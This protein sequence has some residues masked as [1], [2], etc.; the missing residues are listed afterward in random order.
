[1]RFLGLVNNDFGMRYRLVTCRG[2]AYAIF[3]VKWLYIGSLTM[4]AAGSALCGAAPNMKALI[5]GRVW[6]GAGGAG[7]YLGYVG[8][9]PAPLHGTRLANKSASNLNLLTLTTTP[10]E[11]SIYMAL[12]ILVYGVG[13]ILGPIIG[14]SLADSSAT[15]RWVSVL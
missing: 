13:S 4:F 5:V 7:M 10:Q 12:I 14:G 6:A 15:W 2:K 8:Q 3:D 11:R 9:C 1:M